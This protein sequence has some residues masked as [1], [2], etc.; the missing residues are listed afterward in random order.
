MLSK[1]I[2]MALSNEVTS[3]RGIQN[4]RNSNALTSSLEGKDTAP[5]WVWVRAKCLP[6]R[7][8]TRAVLAGGFP[9]GL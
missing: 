6:E 9:P 3:Q 8:S 7:F 5:K 1:A 4:D 2:M